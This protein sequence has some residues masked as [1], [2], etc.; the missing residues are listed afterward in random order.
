MKVQENGIFLGLLAWYIE[1]T[2]WID[3]LTSGIRSKSHYLINQWTLDSVD[4]YVD[5]K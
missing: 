5:E 2:N 4:D 3:Q 1:L